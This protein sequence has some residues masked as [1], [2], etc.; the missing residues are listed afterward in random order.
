MILLLMVIQM[1]III[2]DAWSSLVFHLFREA[3]YEAKHEGENPCGGNYTLLPANHDEFNDNDSDD[4]DD[5]DFC[6]EFEEE[7]IRMTRIWGRRLTRE[8]DL[9]NFDIVVTM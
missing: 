1:T 6:Q 2:I 7:I 4:D 8:K 9:D 5:D 3:G